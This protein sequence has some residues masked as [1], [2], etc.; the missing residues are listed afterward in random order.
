LCAAAREDDHLRFGGGYSE[1]VSVEPA[2]QSVCC[3]L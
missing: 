2:G 3:L 1:T